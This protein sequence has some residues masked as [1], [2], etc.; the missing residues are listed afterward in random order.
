M[1]KLVLFFFLMCSF[2]QANIL[3]E[4]IGQM[5]IVGFKGDN[6]YSKDFQKTLKKIEKN[7]ISGVILFG[8]N[9]SSKQKL[10]EMN[11]AILNAN[12]ITPIISIDNEGGLIQRHAFFD[13]LSANEIANLD[14]NN[15]RK[16]Y[17]NM[18][19]DLAELKI[20]FNYAPVVDLGINQNSIIVKKKRNYGIEPSEIAK[21]SRI[22]IEEHSKNNIATSLKHFPGHG[23]VV[24]DTHKGFVDATNTFEERELKPYKLLINNN[25]KLNTI[26]VSHI[27]NSNFDDKYPASLSKKTIKDKLIDEMGYQGLVVS[28]DLDMGAIRKNYTLKEIVVNT[29]N[30]GINL[31]IFSNNIEYFDKNIDKKIRKIAK[32][33]IK[34]G[35]IKIE[36]I[37]NSYKKII[38]FKKNLLSKTQ[39]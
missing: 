29:I 39:N 8:R 33:E 35:T 21:Y 13:N 20:N 28:D 26:M 5:I 32:K 4:K 14:E 2:A 18:S 23:S 12:P 6:I 17:K 11:E 7:E 38:E 3:D 30:S 27:F 15:A 19:H 16:E 22:L 31:M 37:D 34:K 36:D 10:V 25:D 9:I 24:G 1:R